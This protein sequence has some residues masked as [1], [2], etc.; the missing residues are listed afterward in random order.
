MVNTSN[1]SCFSDISSGATA[2]TSDVVVSGQRFRLRGLRHVPLCATCDLSVVSRTL[3]TRETEHVEHPSN[4]I[5]KGKKS[6]LVE[7]YPFEHLQ[8]GI[9]YLMPLFCFLG[10]WIHCETL[11]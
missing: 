6:H 5:G 8:R 10:S 2:I 11:A 1:P 4:I 3:E 7:K 9:I